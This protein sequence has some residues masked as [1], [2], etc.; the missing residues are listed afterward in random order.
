VV[1]KFRDDK[2][3]IS[4]TLVMVERHIMC[5]GEETD[6]EVEGMVLLVNRTA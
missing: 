5:L 1:L 2:G 6:Q 3:V 4:R